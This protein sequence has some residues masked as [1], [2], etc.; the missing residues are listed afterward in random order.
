MKRLLKAIGGLI[1]KLALVLGY[2][3]IVAAIYGI[4]LAALFAIAE[5]NKT[6]DSKETIVEI[7]N[8]LAQWPYE[9]NESLDINVYSANEQWP[10]E[11]SVQWWPEREKSRP[12]AGANI[13]GVVGRAA[14]SISD[15]ISGF[16]SAITTQYFHVPDKTLTPPKSIP[17]EISL[18]DFPYPS[19][20]ISRENIDW[21]TPLIL[22]DVDFDGDIELIIINHGKGQRGTHSFEI[23][24]IGL[25]GNKLVTTLKNT[26]PFKDM[27]LLDTFDVEKKTITSQSSG[28]ACSSSWE[29]YSV[30]KGTSTPLQVIEYDYDDSGCFKY[31]YIYEKTS[32]GS[33]KVL[34]KKELVK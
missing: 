29:T 27:N 1:H 26:H 6:K 24:D 17:L 8:A 33:S 30:F 5:I 3:I 25:V 4:L 18:S 22:E 23:F 12:Y 14:I 9:P 15:P 32:L 19:L 34:L 10:Y 21:G 16:S 13:P 2:I 11:I 28:G 7:D 31:T 20:K